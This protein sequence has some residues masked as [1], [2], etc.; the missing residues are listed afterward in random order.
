MRIIAWN[1][2]L[3]HATTGV[4]Y[5]WWFL[6]F[7][8]GKNNNF[9]SIQSMFF[10]NIIPCN[11]CQE[12]VKLPAISSRNQE[13]SM[14]SMGILSTNTTQIIFMYSLTRNSFYSNKTKNLVTRGV[15]ISNLGGWSGNLISPI[16]RA[17]RGTI[18]LFSN[19]ILSC[20]HWKLMLEFHIKNHIC[21]QQ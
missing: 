19:L 4:K 7:F 20:W 11:F 13:M 6:Q 3:C 12:L 18:R 17:R 9:K 8:C 1:K 10:I 5:W 2:K 16:R 15:I 14:G 21:I